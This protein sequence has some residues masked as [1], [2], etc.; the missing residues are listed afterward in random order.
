M[1]SYSLSRPA[2]RPDSVQATSI[3][4]RWPAGRGLASTASHR[5]VQAE[6][7]TG[8]AGLLRPLVWGRLS[9]VILFVSSLVCSITFGT[10]LGGGQ[11]ELCN[12]PRAD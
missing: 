3:K 4:A 1:R 2:G 5:P 10:R 12:G 8:A 6:V 9:F 7:T 11:G